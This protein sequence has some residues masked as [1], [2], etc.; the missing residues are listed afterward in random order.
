MRAHPARRKL[1]AASPT[2]PGT[3]VSTE[4][5]REGRF[6]NSSGLLRQLRRQSRRIHPDI[7]L[8]ARPPLHRQP[9]AGV[10]GMEVDLEFVEGA[11]PAPQIQPVR[12]V[13]ERRLGW[14]DV[15]CVS[16]IQLPRGGDCRNHMLPNYRKETQHSGDDRTRFLQNRLY[17]NC[18]RTDPGSRRQAK[19]EKRCC[20]SVRNPSFEEGVLA[21]GIGFPTVA[22]KKARVRTT[23]TATHAR[24]ELDRALEAFRKAGRDLGILGFARLE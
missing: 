2:A 11:A 20:M 17:G 18:G 1:F 8:H 6:R 5:L 19:E 15:E 4:T 3:S 13:R 9:N 10:R 14:V 7:F 24:E 16:V 22:K 23:V 12:H 21:S